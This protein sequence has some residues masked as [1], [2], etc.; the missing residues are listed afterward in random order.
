MMPVMH[1]QTDQMHRI[2]PSPSLL[3]LT[4]GQL[5]FWDEFQAH[6]SQPVSTVAHVIRL[7]GA[8]DQDALAR[9]ITIMAAEAD[10][11]SLRFCEGDPPMQMIDPDRRP[12]LRLLD[13]SGHPRPE[14]EA[15]RAMRADIERPLDLCAD[16]LSALWL[17]RTGPD[18]WMWYLR[19]HHIF[20]DGY[21]M[22]LI[23]R[24]V[25]QLYA[26]LTQATPAGRPFGRFRDY[27]AE[28]ADYRSSPRHQAARAFWQGLLSAGP[29]P[30]TLRKGSEDYPA[31]PRSA[32]LPLQDLST[33]L[34][35]AARR[36]DM[37]WPD[38][39]TA[40]CA[41][42]LWRL[43]ATDP[44]RGPAASEALV[45]LPLMGRMGSVAA[46]VPAMVLNIAPYRV[47]PDP[48]AR[49]ASVLRAIQRDLTV[50][51]QHGRCRIEQIAADFGLED[52]ERFLFSPLINVMPFGDAQFPGCAAA[53]E[54]LAAGPGDGFNMTISA[55]PRAEGLVLHLD[56]D[57]SLTSQ[58]LLEAHAEG[59]PGFLKACLSAGANSALADLPGC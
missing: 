7:E 29:R 8:L 1:G 23:E 27:L 57:P 48:R 37:G 55:D 15:Y 58:A 21:S 4:L 17:I 20:L 28:E 2:T 53:R 50:I 25:A 44:G 39:M 51:R 30:A 14:A 36:L 38:L 19:G 45:W 6:P 34:R 31:A 10:I 59:L 22:A 11:L 56:A 18:R 13:V 16:P 3:P 12:V 35:Q 5:D 52:R 43:P 46:H 24:R 9:A 47:A 41:L 33:P 32:T 42:W 54:V 49:L 40:L 26:H